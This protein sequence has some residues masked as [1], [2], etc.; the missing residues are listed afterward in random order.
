MGR[1]RWIPWPILMQIVISCCFKWPRIDCQNVFFFRFQL[2]VKMAW[3]NPGSIEA[4]QRESNAPSSHFKMTPLLPALYICE[5]TADDL[6]TIFIITGIHWRVGDHLQMNY[7]IGRQK[8]PKEDHCALKM[9]LW[10]H[11]FVAS[12]WKLTFWVIQEFLY[13]P[14]FTWAVGLLL[15]G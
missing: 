5:M 6:Q 9:L 12:V 1:Y 14:F 15:L 2:W 8:E 4:L 10:S 7:Y 11:F 3:S 13:F